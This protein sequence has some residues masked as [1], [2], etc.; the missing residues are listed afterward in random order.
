MEIYEE[1]EFEPEDSS[2][3]AF[4]SADDIKI[5]YNLKFMTDGYDEFVRIVTHEWLHAMFDWATMDDPN[6]LAFNV[7]DCTGESDH[8]IMKV[9]NYD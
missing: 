3:V 8:F 4:Y 1:F 5:T 7:H 6:S 9:I 2:S